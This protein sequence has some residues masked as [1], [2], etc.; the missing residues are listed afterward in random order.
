MN[1]LLHIVFFA[2]VGQFIINDG[3][4][5]SQMCSNIDIKRKL[6]IVNL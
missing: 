3:L 1:A 4:M 6:G 2:G 5:D